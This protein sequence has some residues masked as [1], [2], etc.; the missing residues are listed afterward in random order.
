MD[1]HPT[2]QVIP[3]SSQFWF[4]RYLLLMVGQ[5]ASNHMGNFI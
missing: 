5:E 4:K 3:D 2:L 1:T